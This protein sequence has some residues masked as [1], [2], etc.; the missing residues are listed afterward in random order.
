MTDVRTDDRTAFR[1]CPLCEAGCGLEITV[2]RDDDGRERV[3]RIRGDM[4]DVFSH[5]FIC[6]KGSTLKQLHDD[7][8]RLRAPMIKR[9]GEHVEVSWD[10]AWAEIAAR[11]PD[12]IERHGRQ[13][14]AAY[15]GN[16]T[17]HSL[18]AMTFSR[19]LLTGLGTRV[20]FS[21]STV[22]QMPR[23]VA[24]GHVFGSPVA[25]PV[26]DLDRT[27]HLVILG[28]NPYA[29]N[30]SVCTAPDFP[31]RIE[32]IQERGGKV[33]VVDPRRSRTA[34]Q[35][36]QWVSIRP[37][38]DALLLA[39]IA[40]VLLA[41]GLADVGDHVREHIAG[42]DRLGAA[43]DAFA[44]EA[45]A[46]STGVDADTIRS[47]A[48]ELAAAPTAAVYGRIG[49]TTTEFGST[50][51]WLVDVVNT[52]SGNLDRPGGSMFA[53]PVAGGATTRGRRGSGKGFRVGRGQSRVSGHPEVMGEYPVN[54]L[55]EEITT[56]GDGQVRGLVTLAGN[57][58]LS[59][60]N[61]DQLADALDDLEFMVSIDMYLNETT[62]H[63]DVILPV[64]SQLQR[65]HYDVLLLQ[66]A[67]RNV[68]N[69]SPP[70]LPL[71]DG[72][73]DEWEVIARLSLIAQGMGADA[74]PALVDDLAIDGLI[75][76]AVKD[77]NSNVYGRDAD[78]LRSALD[79]SGRRGPDRMVDFM[80]RTGPFG[81]GFGADPDGTSLDD[82]LENPHGR[83]FGALVPRLPEILRTPSGVVELAPDV[84]LDDLDR[85][86]AAIPELDDRSLVLV[87][88]RHLRSN[89]SWMHNINVLVKGAPRCTLQVH[90]DDA[91][92]LGLAHGG[93]ARVTS[94]VGH[95]VAP[96]E[97]TDSIRPGVVSLPHGWG[98]DLP[99]ARM[100]IAAEHAG[101]NSNVLSD[102]RS[103]DP[104][105]GTSVLN[106]IPVDLEPA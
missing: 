12:L 33:V 60:P 9:D 81:D 6:P 27:D 22:D 3:Q 80:L 78:E 29:S 90:P 50:A 102:D 39:A 13:S 20:R 67:V 24:A 103:M 57:P 35:A 105:S 30:G 42:L 91:V 88:R 26:P 95:V 61:S 31:G 11:L 46:A 45:V 53:T 64:P 69:Y 34:E 28:A 17:A 101:V 49:T 52:L 73:I 36:D 44:P 87:G 14:L 85:L 58:V 15:I 41:E 51:S 19:A 54:C 66:F 89:N 93:A 99:G 59:T 56:P 82:L 98:H 32:A 94:R 48:R 97:V 65:A 55:A 18:S 86:A 25:I 5:G 92:A 74:D 43:L 16:P 47:M 104:L 70:V 100:R 84:F 8:D 96:V 76:S 83:D 75:G 37:G 38:T 2:G 72:E 62:R 4:D 63:A 1:T 21:A 106:G 71:G 79:A 7:P 23:H 40:H 68:A 10:E 77:E